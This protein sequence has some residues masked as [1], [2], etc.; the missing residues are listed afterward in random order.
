M[1]SLT[2]VVV[3]IGHAQYVQNKSRQKWAS[4]EERL[5]GAIENWGREFEKAF[6][7]AFKDEFARR[8]C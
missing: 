1:A 4:V 2:V 5:E 6:K 3:V 7:K 8:L